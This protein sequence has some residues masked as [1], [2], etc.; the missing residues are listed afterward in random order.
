MRR[1]TLSPPAVRQA[2]VVPV[3]VEDQQR[4]A[5]AVEARG[6]DQYL[7][8]AGVRFGQRYLATSGDSSQMP[9]PIS[10]SAMVV[11]RKRPHVKG[12]GRAAGLTHPDAAALGVRP[13]VRDH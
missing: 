7:R 2:C 10:L 11:W 1:R 3:G 5:D 4:V 12:L 8:T 13:V 9:V 6:G